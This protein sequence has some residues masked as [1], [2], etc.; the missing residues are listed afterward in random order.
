MQDS[1]PSAPSKGA[2]HD[3]IA[4]QLLP[5]FIRLRDAPAYLGMDKNRFNR[6]VVRPHLCRIPIGR[7]GV[8]FDRV[9]LDTWADDYKCRNGASRGSISKE[10]A[11]GNQRTPDL[12][13]RK[14]I[15]HI[16][17]RFRGARICEST[18][19]SPASLIDQF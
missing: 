1:A 7:Q 15:W 18:G 10:Q 16:D 4:T 6:D 13:K 17:K 12:Q 8:A 5:R 14:G 19:T 3:V 9:D 11:M 2:L